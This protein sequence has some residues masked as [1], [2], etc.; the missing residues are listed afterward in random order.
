MIR[1][2][3]CVLAAALPCAAAT[4]LIVTVTEQKS[5]RPITGLTASDFTVIDDKSPRRV[6]SAES[7]SG[8]LD[9]V[10]M[11]DTSAAGATV[12]P[13][14]SDLI[15]QLQPNEQMSVVSFH[16]SADLIQDFTSS[17]ELLRRAVQSV[18]YGNSPRVL[19]ALYAVLDGGFQSSD[20][21][22]VIA[23]LTT[24]FEASARVNE[25]DVVRLARKSGVSIFPTYMV[26]Y[27]KSLFEQLARQTGG[28]P[29]HVPDMRKAGIP[30]PGATL[31]D[32]M[33]HHYVLTISGNQDPSDKLKITINRPEKYMASA[34]V[35]E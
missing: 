17:K 11:V 6:E 10:L 3:I 7:A 31:F 26:G 1:A 21:R 14:A 9:I 4:K 28:A 8:S 18:R 20:F 27:S 25:K 13:L 33:R 29:F 22:R 12:Q 19:D 2:L 32:V 24:G 16:S 23:L 35:L 30:R 15:A 5:S 34:L